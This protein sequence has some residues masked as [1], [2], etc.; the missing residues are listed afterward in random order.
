MLVSGT[1]A[2]A[3]R[4][5]GPARLLSVIFLAALAAAVSGVVLVALMMATRPPDVALVAAGEEAESGGLFLRIDS[6]EWLDHEEAH[7]DQGE[8]FPMP[9]SAMP[10]MPADGLERLHVEVSVR[11]PGD[12]AHEITPGDFR[13]SSV[14]GDSW[15][16]MASTLP[17]S[18]LGPRQALNGVVFFD[19]PEGESGV[20]FVWSAGG[21]EAYM[22]I[23]DVP[24]HDH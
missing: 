13:V 23:G 14:G 11:N 24:L 10:D 21:S 6:S 16:P 18:E 4:A 1:R 5:E 9:A 20:Y 17:P 15:P 8:V 22:P 12:G 2:R 7:R 3:R 19:V